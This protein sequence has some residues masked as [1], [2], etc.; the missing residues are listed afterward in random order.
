M[1]T[2]S[3]Y[4]DSVNMVNKT[5]AVMYGEQISAPEMISTS[6][7][8]SSSLGNHIPLQTGTLVKSSIPMTHDVITLVKF[9]K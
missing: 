7:Y 5:I 2:F 8:S 6:T 4:D 1:N 9:P 3:G